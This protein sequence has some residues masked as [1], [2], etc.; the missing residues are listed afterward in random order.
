[1]GKGY[2]YA[3]L[4]YVDETI[5]TDDYTVVMKLKK[6]SYAFLP[7]V[8]MTFRIQNE[9]LIMDNLAEGE[10]GDMGDYGEDWLRTHDAGSGPYYV[11]EFILENHLMMRKFDDYWMDKL[12][13]THPDRPEEVWEMSVEESITQRTMYMNRELEYNH[14]FGARE[15]YLALAEID[16]VR[17]VDLRG[18]AAGMWGPMS[19]K[20]HQS[21]PPMDDINLRKAFAW[22]MDYKTFASEIST[23]YGTPEELA[24]WESR[25]CYGLV[26]AGVPGTL[27]AA[28]G[29]LEPKYEQDLDKALEYLQ[30]CKYYLDGTL[31]DYEIVIEWTAECPDREKMGILFAS[32]V[33]Q[34]SE[35][36]GVDINIKILKT[37]WLQNKETWSQ[38]DTS[39][40]GMVYA[41]GWQ[42]QYGDVGG[43][44]EY[45]CSWLFGT[46]SSH[47]WGYNETIEE[48]FLQAVETLDREERFKIW[49]QM[50]RH[51]YRQVPGAFMG[52]E[53]QPC[54]YQE[55]YL[56]WYVMEEGVYPPFD[57]LKYDF[58]YIGID[59]E[60]K[61]EL[62]GS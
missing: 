55:A 12:E 6:P 19:I 2:A 22:A 33:Q 16:G 49:A 50:Q 37:P 28:R 58:R 59:A 7:I 56:D 31:S 8:F 41:Y 61:A 53:A 11:E 18:G 35:M 13:L 4:P 43:A 38:S 27:S 29:E 36:A 47:Y 42:S 17:T 45:Y 57:S 21:M 24:D 51:L 3:L 25:R 46:T 23:G 34:L 44:L 26:S 5:A 20:F 60:K 62:L 54:S 14:Q 52:M 39:P 40:H 32:S 1:M 30:Q 9:D 10:F 15:H 48:M